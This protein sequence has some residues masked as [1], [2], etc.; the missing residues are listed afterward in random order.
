MSHFPI[1]LLLLASLFLLLRAL[2]DNKWIVQFERSTPALLVLGLIGVAGA[3]VT[4]LVLWPQEAVL[5]SPMAKNKLLFT[6]WSMAAWLGVAA[7]RLRA[8]EALWQSSVRW[9]LLILVLLAAAL[10]GITGALGGYLIG[11]PSDFSALLKM[12]G[13][14]VYQTFHAPMWAL[15][16]AVLMAVAIMAIGLSTKTR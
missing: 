3:V 13:W 15:G 5:A 6:F 8:G 1:A 16:V 11:A 9:P 7:I 10:L 4:G 12:S 2:S 14:N